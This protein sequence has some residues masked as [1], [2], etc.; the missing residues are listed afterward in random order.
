[1]NKKYT[2]LLNSLRRLT[3]KAVSYTIKH[4]W[5]PKIPKHSW[6][7]L[8]QLDL[9]KNLFCKKN[10]ITNWTEYSDAKKE[11]KKHN[12]FMAHA[13]HVVGTVVMNSKYS[14]D[15]Y[16]QNFLLWYITENKDYSDE[17]YSCCFTEFV[18]FFKHEI[19]EIHQECKLF[20]FILDA[21][22]DDINF[23]DEIK[24]IKKTDKSHNQGSVKYNIFSK[25]SD[26]ILFQSY[27][28]KK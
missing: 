18:D 22:L 5:I 15:D 13:D 17:T 2:P 6:I 26:F 23:D 28:A 10:P 12:V 8:D 24:I 7:P 20:N 11:F 16:I 21:G 4:S 19:I 3:K 9:E 1:M 27:P 25:S 14:V